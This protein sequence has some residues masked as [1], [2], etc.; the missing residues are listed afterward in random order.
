MTGGCEMPVESW[1]GAVDVDLSDTLSTVEMCF[2]AP[3]LVEA[4]VRRAV[5]PRKL[6][7]VPAVAKNVPDAHAKRGRRRR[8]FIRFK[9]ILTDF[10]SNHAGEQN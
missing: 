6:C 5:A 2:A 4:Y 9:F 8:W 7:S 3:P 10:S 1:P